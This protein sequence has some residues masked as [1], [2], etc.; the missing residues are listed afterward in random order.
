[1]ENIAAVTAHLARKGERTLAYVPARAGAPLAWDA[2]GS[3]WRMSEFIDGAMMLERARDA[4]DA[5]RAA[6]AFG[7]FQR[8]LADYA[9]APL[10][11]TLAGFHDTAARV[12]AL[13]RA[14]SADSHARATRAHDVLAGLERHRGR[15]AGFFAAARIAHPAF[16]RIAHHDAK[17]ANVLF[18][19]RGNA[20][21]VIDLD[22]VMPGLS[23]YDFG[24][25]MRSMV[26]A[27]A[28]DEPDPARVHAE[29]ARYAAIVRGYLAGTG[30]MLGDAERH[31]L[32]GAAEAM[33]F[34]QSVRFLTDFLEG[35]RYYRVAR[36]EHNLERARA[37]LALLDSLAEQRAEFHRMVEG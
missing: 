31:L 15:L 34:E 8:A 21:C 32:P 17:I 28:E 7:R 20:I 23:L 33:T 27:A 4:A 12:A 16:E 11:A 25:L 35:D 30:A 3:C 2:G 24:D 22:T 18:D 6:D 37:Q 36:P 13:G 9:G 29:A 14:T 1:M 5:E 19:A 10:H 26:S